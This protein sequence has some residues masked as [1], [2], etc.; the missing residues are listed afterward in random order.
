MHACE[1]TLACKQAALR[2]LWLLHSILVT[3]IEGTAAIM[4]CR[5]SMGTGAHVVQVDVS[6]THA[7]GGRA[8]RCASMTCGL[9]SSTTHACKEQCDQ[10]SSSG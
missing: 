2:P 5:S 10:R 7:P 1:R 4:Y 8:G 6:D 9:A 3:A